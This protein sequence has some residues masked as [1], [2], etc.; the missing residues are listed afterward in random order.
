VNVDAF[1]ESLDRAGNA[2]F[3]EHCRAVAVELQEG[4]FAGTNSLA[5]QIS[6][7]QPMTVEDFVTKNRNIFI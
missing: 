1:A 4:V 2:L 3:K 5:A 6:G 7:Q